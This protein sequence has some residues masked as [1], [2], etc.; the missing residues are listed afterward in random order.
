VIFLQ[1]SQSFYWQPEAAEAETAKAAGKLAP[2]I[3]SR[4]KNDELGSAQ[5]TAWWK[6]QKNGS[7]DKQFYEERGGTEIWKGRASTGQ[8]FL[9]LYVPALPA[10]NMEHGYSETLLRLGCI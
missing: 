7:V 4:R 1:V 3:I 9:E 5:Q 2:S 8:N 10:D 6:F